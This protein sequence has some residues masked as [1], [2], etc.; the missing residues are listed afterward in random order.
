MRI[1]RL[2]FVAL[3][4]AFV[5]REKPVFEIRWDNVYDYVPQNDEIRDVGGEFVEPPVYV[6]IPEMEWRSLI[7]PASGVWNGWADPYVAPP[8]D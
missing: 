7:D 2:W 6:P 3:L 1:V 8:Q 5:L 4:V